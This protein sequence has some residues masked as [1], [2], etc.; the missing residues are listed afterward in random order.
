MKAVIH[1]KSSKLYKIRYK[2]KAKGIPAFV[3]AL[4]RLSFKADDLQ[5]NY[6]EIGKSH[7]IIDYSLVKEPEKSKKKVR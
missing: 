7:G 3:P 4:S 5:L 1:N 6:L 2:A